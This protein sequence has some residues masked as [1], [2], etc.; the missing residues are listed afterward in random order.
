M[1]KDLLM[2]Y[3]NYL[4]S[5]RYREEFGSKYCDTKELINMYEKELKINKTYEKELKIY[6]KKTK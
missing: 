1:K 5:I 6:K 4:Y 2:T 3:R